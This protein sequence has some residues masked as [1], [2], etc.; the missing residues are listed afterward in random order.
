MINVIK[1][2][3]LCLDLQVLRQTLIETAQADDGSCH[4]YQIGCHSFSIQMDLVK[5]NEQA[6]ELTSRER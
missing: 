3:H 1:N 2:L 6:V 4:I 5:T